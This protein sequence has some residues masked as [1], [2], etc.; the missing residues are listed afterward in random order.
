MEIPQV[1]PK[2]II[3]FLPCVLFQVSSVFIRHTNPGSLIVMQKKERYGV[4]ERHA[5][6]ERLPAMEILIFLLFKMQNSKALL[7]P[8]YTKI[9]HA[10]KY[11]DW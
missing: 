4:L 3:L 7:A 1:Y 5:E 2:P 6:P 9:L 8:S 11:H 10:E